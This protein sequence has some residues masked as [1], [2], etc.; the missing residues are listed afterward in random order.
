MSKRGEMYVGYLGMPA[1]HGRFVRGM[2][3]AVFAVV[4]GVG[5]LIAGVQRDPGGGVWE[6]GEARE[7]EGVLIEE[8]Y[9]VLID[10][11]GSAH[12]LVGVG[13][14]GVKDRVAGLSGR[15]RIRGYALER[16][17]RRMIEVLDGDDGI[18]ALEENAGRIGM[19]IELVREHLELAGEVLDSKCY[20][21]A[22]KPG[23]G[24]GHKACA[25][26]C[27]EGG[28]PPMLFVDGKD[29]SRETYLLVDAEGESARNIVLEFVGEPVV[30]KGRVGKIAD[31]DVVAIESIERV[32]R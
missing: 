20:L 23:D 19:D 11:E 31:L 12:L 6:T 5:G 8:P 1:R 21:G 27:I 32:M 7:W 10:A 17:G 26:L 4:V 24:K 9:P 29:G 28:I 22:M 18:E 15:A 30:V 14:F 3:A 25:T 13:K 16:D 2:V